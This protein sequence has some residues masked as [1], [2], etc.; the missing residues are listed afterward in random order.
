MIKKKPSQGKIKEIDL[1]FKDHK[2]LHEENLNE[3]LRKLRLIV[4]KSL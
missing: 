2:L 3:I 1:R 4:C